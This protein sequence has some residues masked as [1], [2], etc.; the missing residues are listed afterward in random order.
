MDLA[1]WVSCSTADARRR[2]LYDLVPILEG[3]AGLTAG[4]R[5][6]PWNHDA[7][8]HPRPDQSQQAQGSNDP[9]NHR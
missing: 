1:D 8:G 7:A 2:G 3:L 4:L 5:A 9:S 6:A